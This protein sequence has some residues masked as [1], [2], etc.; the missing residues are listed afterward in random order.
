MK[1]STF[2]D[3]LTQGRGGWRH[4]FT[5]QAW[6]AKYLQP[7]IKSEKI[8]INNLGISGQTMLQIANRLEKAFPADFITFMGGTNDIW[9]FL[10]PDPSMEEEMA[11]NL[12]QI[13]EENVI[14]KFNSL[15]KSNPE[16]SVLILSTIPSDCKCSYINSPN[17][18]RNF[19]C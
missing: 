9:H 10:G 18:T 3:S 7:K 8:Q 2:G 17:A 19:R 12:I 11:N 15:S 1:I 14:A 5:Y 13:L 16:K 4:E 6:L